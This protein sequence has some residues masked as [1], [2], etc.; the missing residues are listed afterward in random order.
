MLLAFLKKHPEIEADGEMREILRCR[1]RD[2]SFA[3]F[4]AGRRS[5]YP[6]DAGSTAATFAYQTVKARENAF[7][8]EP[9]RIGLACPG[10]ASH[11]CN[12][13]RARWCPDMTWLTVGQKMSGV[14]NRPCSAN[15]KALNVWFR[16]CSFEKGQAKATIIVSCP[17]TFAL[18][19]SADHV[20]LDPLRR[21]VLFAVLLCIGRTSLKFAIQHRARISSSATKAGHS[22]PLAPYT[23]NSKP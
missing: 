22:A 13:R 9:Y 12:H 5:Q 16:F 14:S 3:Q 6:D 7:P 21:K 1:H 20:S 8:S 10:A 17:R 18:P 19:F 2:P 11:A 4:Q 15:S 23:S